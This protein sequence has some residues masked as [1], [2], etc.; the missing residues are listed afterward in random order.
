MKNLLKSLLL[1][2]AIVATTAQAQTRIEVGIGHT[3]QAPTTQAATR[4]QHA[5]AHVN[6]LL[7]QQ[8]ARHEAKQAPA[9]RTT[10]E[11]AER[12]IMATTYNITD[13]FGNLIGLNDSTR[14]TYSNGRG[15]Q[16]NYNHMAFDG[17][18][19]MAADIVMGFGGDIGFPDR[20]NAPTILY[21]TAMLFYSYIFG[22]DRVRYRYLNVYQ[23]DTH[24]NI[25]KWESNDITAGPT[26]YQMFD[27][28]YNIY[29]N[30]TA[31]I[32]YDALYGPLDTNTVRVFN[33]N[34]S[35]VVISDSSTD[36]NVSNVLTPADR[37]VYTYDDS[38]NMVH[39][40]AMR[41]SAGV[42]FN[43]Q[44]FFMS[45]YLNNKLQW[46]SSIGFQAGAWYTIGVDSFSY[47]PGIDYVTDERNWQYNMGS[48]LSYNKYIKH[49]D[50][51]G[52]PD[53]MFVTKYNNSIGNRYQ[54]SKYGYTYDAKQEPT[55]SRQYNFHITDTLTNTGWWDTIPQYINY[56]YYELYHKTNQLPYGP[57]HTDAYTLYPNPTTGKLNLAQN[58]PVDGKQGY[59]VLNYAGQTLISGTVNF[60]GGTSQLDLGNLSPGVYLVE[61]RDAQ[62]AT[63]T[64]RVVVEK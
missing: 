29:G 45:Y 57:T 34:S 33:Y 21:D 17:N 62:G 15:S 6:N 5:I 13:S 20:N 40:T 38:G 42:W 25:T 60:L 41:D 44:Q 64:F 30:I 14:Y 36:R 63:A 55:T 58:T 10:D 1:P 31:N 61:M 54:M 47:T 32:E 35:Q 37:W 4:Q 2:L 43:A 46:D 49:I 52:Q 22:W 18:V 9:A 56:Y 39:A 50:T 11:I 23:Y 48:L 53:T 51:A 16:F 8:D 12:L 27:N 59:R 24:N 19:Y 26:G 28:Y 7:R 3:P